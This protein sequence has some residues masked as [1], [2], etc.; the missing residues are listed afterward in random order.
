[1]FLNVV[2]ILIKFLLEFGLNPGFA[3]VCLFVFLRTTQIVFGVQFL[4]PHGAQA[5]IAFSYYW[6]LLL[7]LLLLSFPNILLKPLK[8]NV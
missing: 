6:T 3:L 1:M 5:V 8:T 4:A 7:L 2:F